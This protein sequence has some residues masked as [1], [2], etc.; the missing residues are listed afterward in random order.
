LISIEEL[1][2]SILELEQRDTTYV[3]CSKLADLYTVR[4]HLSGQQ[5][6]QPTPLSTSGDSEFLQ[7]VDGKDSVQVWKIMDELV[8]TLKVVNS[9][10]YDSVMRKIQSLS[11]E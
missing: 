10:A 11:K 7:A 1:D 3:N 9:R 8:G 6:K 4:D 5:S 2:K